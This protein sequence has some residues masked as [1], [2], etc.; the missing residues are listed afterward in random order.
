MTFVPS[1][2]LCLSICLLAFFIVSILIPMIIRLSYKWNLLD[3]PDHRKSHIQSIPNLGG[4]SFYL[5][6]WV[7]YSLF[8]H[9]QKIC[10]GYLLDHLYYYL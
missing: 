4:I 10:W 2:T 1:L 7:S 9:S 5:A 3:E 8:L 6:F